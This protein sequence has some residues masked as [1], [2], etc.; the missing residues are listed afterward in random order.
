MLG[1]SRSVVVRAAAKAI[2]T[3]GSSASWPPACSHFCD[4]AGWSV[5][6]KPWK[7]AASAAA[8]RVVAIHY[9][10][11]A[12]LPLIPGSECAGTVLEAADDVT[13]IAAG[14]RV[15]GAVFVG[16]FAEQVVVDASAVTKVP[17]EVDLHDCAA[18]GVAR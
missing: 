3:N 4:G 17:A 1:I 16:A 7:P 14:D 8:A 6:P 10:M 9:E 11:P 15:L 2:A 5:N 18:F 12:P 13:H